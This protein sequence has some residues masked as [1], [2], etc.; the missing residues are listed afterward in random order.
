MICA[1]LSTRYPAQA[2]AGNLIVQK[3]WAGTWLEA[4]GSDGFMQ[5]HDVLRCVQ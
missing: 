2:A 3:C 5:E 1:C 4:D